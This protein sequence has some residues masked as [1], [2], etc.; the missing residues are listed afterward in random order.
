MLLFLV[1]TTPKPSANPHE[2]CGN[3]SILETE[4]GI[5]SSNYVPKLKFMG[6]DFV[7]FSFN[8]FIIENFF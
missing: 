4:K 3:R 1:K 7:Y 5:L 6:S 2:A 8:D